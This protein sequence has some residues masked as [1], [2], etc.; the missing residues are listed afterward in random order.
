MAY[1]TRT[2]ENIVK[3]KYELYDFGRGDTKLIID[4]AKIFKVQLDESR[5]EDYTITNLEYWNSKISTP[6]ITIYDLKNKIQ[7]TSKI[8]SVPS[9]GNVFPGN[10]DEYFEIRISSKKGI[11]TKAYYT[12]KDEDKPIVEQLEFNLGE[13]SI[14]FKREDYKQ[15]YPNPDYNRELII[16][17]YEK[18]RHGELFFN[19]YLDYEDG[20]YHYFEQKACQ[21]VKAFRNKYDCPDN[22]I[23]CDDSNLIYAIQS[24]FNSINCTANGIF[25]EKS[26]KICN[27]ERYL[28]KVFPINI[29]YNNFSNIKLPNVESFMVYLPHDKEKKEH[30]RFEICKTNEKI[31]INCKYLLWDNN[32]GWI[33]AQEENIELPIMNIGPI[34]GEEV[35]SV[36]NV[37][38]TKCD[39]NI[40]KILCDDFLT[41]ADMLDDRSKSLTEYDMLSSKK[42]FNTSFEDILEEVG[43]HKEKYFALAESQFKEMAY[44][45]KEKVPTRILKLK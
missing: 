36:T 33:T 12:W 9:I 16:F 37:L 10:D 28:R 15:I 42:L 2:L 5:L 11:L 8:T 27:D 6:S 23:Y 35:R 39:G 40:R 30:T 20:C 14:V 26:K 3:G 17:Y 7:I 43:N 1:Y 29:G 19:K 31:I 34:T 32:K 4:L 21:H 22:Y 44:A 38:Q 25:I 41:Y 18:D 24:N 13:N 45:E